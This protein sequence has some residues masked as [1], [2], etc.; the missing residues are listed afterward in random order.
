MKV[1]H[2][3]KTSV[4][5]TW[6]LRQI[7]ELIKNGVEIVV[8]MPDGP[9]VRHYREA[10]AEVALEQFDFAVKKPMLVIERCARLRKL[11][12]QC[13]PNIVQSHFVGTTITMRLALRG[14]RSLPRIFMVPGPL[15]L[16]HFLFR[17][18]EL[19][20]SQPN[21]FWIA[22]CKWTRDCYIRNKI[23]AERVGLSYYGGYPEEFERR[24]KGVLR[25]ELGLDRNAKIVGMVAYMYAPKHYL[26]QSRG[27][28][29][30]EDLMDAIVLC[31]KRDKNIHGVFVGGAWGSS[32]AW[33]EKK[34]RE[35]A[36]SICPEGLHL[37]GSRSD[38]PDIYPD[39][40]LVAHPSHSENLGGT[41]ESS[42]AGKA[43]IASNVGGF[44]D[45]IIHGETGLLSK[46]GSPEDLAEKIM[47]MFD[48]P[49]QAETMS[50]NA[51]KLVS[52]MCDVRNNAKV[53]AGFYDKIL[54]KG[55]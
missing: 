52:D 17:K 23:A 42:L 9:L 35:Y 41:V 13:R 30:H 31:R 51:Y 50:K 54:H 53:I 39:F 8:A 48:H 24:D 18:M 32:A 38:I 12:D 11:V 28:K 6:A 29:G 4:G 21:D 37:L 27:L 46:P 1:L 22:S 26:M 40:D 25:T 47:Y 19:A 34:L 43:S 3:L 55:N 14:Y 7:T 33:Y 16:E 20:L 44:P 49:E 45:V 36:A 5:A 15:H 10:G 2:L